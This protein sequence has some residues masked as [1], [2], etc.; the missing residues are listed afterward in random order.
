MLPKR[1]IR[2]GDLVTTK[3]GYTGRVTKKLGN[4][5]ELDGRVIVDKMNYIKKIE[6]LRT[7]AIQHNDWNIMQKYL[8]GCKYDT[9]Y[10]EI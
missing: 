1:L 7:G 2:I 10:K 9:E 6:C 5:L 3:R 8:V 4:G